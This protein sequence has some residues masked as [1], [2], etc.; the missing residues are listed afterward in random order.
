MRTQVFTK[1]PF[2]YEIGM[3]GIIRVE[4]ITPDGWQGAIIQESGLTSGGFSWGEQPDCAI[5]LLFDNVTGVVTVI[6]K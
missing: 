1:V 4:H 6:E 2:E 3:G 5:T